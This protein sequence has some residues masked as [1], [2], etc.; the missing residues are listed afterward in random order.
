MTAQW[1][2]STIIKGNIV[3][4]KNMLTLKLEPIYFSSGHQGDRKTDH[5]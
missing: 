2:N 3:M 1:S 5:K 4:L